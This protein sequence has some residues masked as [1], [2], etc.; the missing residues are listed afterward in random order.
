MPKNR[1]IYDIIQQIAPF[2]NQ[3]EFDNAGFLVGDREAECRG[4][5][6]ALDVT[7][8]AIRCAVEE[9]CNLIVTHHPVI[10]EPLKTV[11]AESLVFKLIK[12]GLSVISA[13]TNL[14]MSEGGVN[15][16][17]AQRLGL[18]DVCGV[19]PFG[20]VY[21]A[22]I[23]KTE[24]PLSPNEFASYLKQRLPNAAIKYVAGKTAIKKVGV[25]SGSG[26]SLLK[27]MAAQQVDAFVTADVKHNVF[28]ESAQLGISLYDCGHFDTEDVIV[29]KLKAQLLKEFGIKT[30]AFHS[31]LIRSL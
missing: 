6:V 18:C 1:E 25:C 9:G 11:T 10:F 5:L 13:H 20:E 14:D 16:T 17:L 19:V 26:G 7:E 28:L 27:E 4:I 24:S 2:Q 22:R 29:D 3:M 8:E 31:E 15:D 21:E 30:V 23:G 12:N